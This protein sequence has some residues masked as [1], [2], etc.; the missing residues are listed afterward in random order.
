M[1]LTSIRDL[2]RDEVV[3][4]LHDMEEERF[5]LKIR[6]SIKD[7]DN[8]LKLRTLDR[9]IAR[10]KTVLREDELDIRPLAKQKT[11]LLSEAESGKNDRG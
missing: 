10:L 6:R 1:K 7:L 2:T 9:D 4:R 8:P 11:T 5:N 3:L